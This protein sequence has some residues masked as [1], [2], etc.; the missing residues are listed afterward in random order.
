MPEVPFQTGGFTGI[1]YSETNVWLVD[2]REVDENPHQ[3][4]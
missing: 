4:R 1:T 2:T 3:L